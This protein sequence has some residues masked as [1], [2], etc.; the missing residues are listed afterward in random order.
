MLNLLSNAV[1]Y[2]EGGSV[3]VQTRLISDLK[4]GEKQSAIRISVSDTGIGIKEDDIPKLFNSFVRLDSPLKEK[5]SGT[6]LGLYLTNKIMK[7][8]FNG[9]IC[10]ESRYGKDSTYTLN[11]DGHKASGYRRCRG[12]QK[13]KELKKISFSKKR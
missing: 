4:E 7:S 1:K 10:V 11:P 9:D 2:S 12:D 6:G 8:I 5:T 3:T 13:V